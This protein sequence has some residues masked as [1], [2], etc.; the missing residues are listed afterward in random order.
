MIG[1]EFAAI[2]KFAVAGDHLGVVIDARKNTAD[3]GNHPARF[4]AARKIDKWVYPV[5]GEVTKVHDVCGL[6]VD[7]RITVGMRRRDV[8]R[9]NRQTIEVQ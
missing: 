5:E 1:L 3:S 6:E 9:T 7:H 2:R 8:L 4:A